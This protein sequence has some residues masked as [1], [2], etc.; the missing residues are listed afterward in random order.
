MELKEHLHPPTFT[1]R[2]HCSLAMHC[3]DSLEEAGSSEDSAAPEK[4]R[5]A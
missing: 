4:S 3:N 5:L 1:G 2:R